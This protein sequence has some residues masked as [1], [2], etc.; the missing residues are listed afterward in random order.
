MNEFSINEVA[1]LT[2]RTV[3]FIRREVASGA[4]KSYKKGNKTSILEEDYNNWKISIDKKFNEFA[5][6]SDPIKNSK[7]NKIKKKND[8][9]CWVDISS[10]MMAIDGWANNQHIRDFNFIDLFTGAVDFLVG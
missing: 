9:V 1:E 3:K 4:L 8:I 7:I 2:G 5:S 10:E 6:Y